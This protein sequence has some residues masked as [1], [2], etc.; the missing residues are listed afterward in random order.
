MKNNFQ[1]SVVLHFLVFF[2]IYSVQLK[3]IPWGVGSRIVL[4]LFGIGT[5]IF[6]MLHKPNI[7]RISKNLFFIIIFLSAIALISIFS[8]LINGTRDLKFIEYP[9]SIVLILFAGYFIANTFNKSHSGK[10][11]ND[12]F[13]LLSNVLINVV[14]IQ[15]II[16]L[17]MFL[18]PSF[19]DALNNIQTTS[20]LEKTNLEN[21][22]EFRLSGFGCR[23]FGAGILNGYAL[24]LIA[25]KIKAGYSSIGRTIYLALSFLLILVIGMMMA[26]TTIIGAALGFILLSLPSN[27]NIKFHLRIV[28]AKLI[29]LFSIIILPVMIAAILFFSAPKFTDNITYAFTFGFEMFINYFENGELKSE[30]TSSL[31]EMYVFPSTSQTY[32]IGDGYYTDPNDSNA[33]YMG[34]DVGYLRLIFYFGIMGLLAHILLQLHA[35]R[36]AINGN[37]QYKMFFYFTFIFYLVLNFKGF[38]DILFLSVLFW[39]INYNEYSLNNSDTK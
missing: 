13:T 8:I 18:V 36:I 12:K 11:P 24:I 39:M 21:T 15:V 23:F 1:K 3:V 33:Y 31:Q 14:L 9:L 38:A 25:S 16:S 30:S 17:I 34:T 2:Y 19:N 28:R 27:L 26:R 5:L 29:F 35:I 37:F 6:S 4:S 22:L 32:I 10:T 20:E 7:L